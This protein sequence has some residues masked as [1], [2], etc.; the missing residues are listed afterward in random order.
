[1]NVA[2]VDTA[3]HLGAFL[4]MDGALLASIDLAQK[5]AYTAALFEQTTRELARKAQPGQPLFGMSTDRFV[6][7]AGGVPLH[8]RGGIIGAIGVSSGTVQED[9]AVAQAGAAALRH[10][11]EP[12]GA[13]RDRSAV[14]P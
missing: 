12:E 5:K 8:A 14:A 11:K 1:M 7:I 3:G 4:R 2:I 6:P 9:E 13:H 10:R